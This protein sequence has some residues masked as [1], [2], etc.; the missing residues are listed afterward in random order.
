MTTTLIVDDEMDI[1]M[2]VRTIIELANDG[3]EVVGE[4]AD[5]DEAMAMWRALDPPPIPD[6]IVLDN[7]MPGRTGLEVATE[8]LSEMPEQIVVLYSAYM[9]QSVRSQAAEIGISACL[10][11]EQLDELPDLIRRLAAM[12]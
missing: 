1:R 9:D 10:Q 8:I 4:A 6:V 5:G 3:L 2:L 12:A 7:R 11:K